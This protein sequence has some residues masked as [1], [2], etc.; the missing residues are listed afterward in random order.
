MKEKENGKKKLN[1]NGEWGYG[2]EEEGNEEGDKENEDEKR[3]DRIN[4]GRK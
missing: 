1:V 2:K 3:G 4:N